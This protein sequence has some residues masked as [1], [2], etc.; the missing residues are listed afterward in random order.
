MKGMAVYHGWSSSETGSLG[1]IGGSL[2]T[3]PAVGI[4][5]SG[6]DHPVDGGGN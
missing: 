2:D 6:R 3:S 5:G 1:P 4:G